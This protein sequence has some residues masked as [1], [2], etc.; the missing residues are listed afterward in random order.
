MLTYLSASSFMNLSSIFSS[1]TALIKAS[2]ALLT[3]LSMSSFSACDQSL[4]AWCSELSVWTRYCL[5][6]LLTFFHLK[7]S[8]L[9]LIQISL[10]DR[11]ESYDSA[12]APWPHAWSVTNLSF[13][14]W[15][16]FSVSCGHSGEASAIYIEEYSKWVFIWLR[17]WL[18][19]RSTAQLSWVSVFLNRS[20]IIS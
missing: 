12:A 2:Y 15:H 1:C 10:N 9:S 7:I 8:S 18:T 19:F 16:E 14:G 13:W 11:S 6:S 20:A 4:K 3:L 5:L 17:V